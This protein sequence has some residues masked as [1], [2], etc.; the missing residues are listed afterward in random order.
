M[1]KKEQDFGVNDFAKKNIKIYDDA[2]IIG[3]ENIDF[4]HDI[5]IDDFVF[6]VA[7]KTIRIGNYVH[8]GAFS[9]IL[10]GEEL[11]MG[12]F[13][14]I[15]QGARIYTATEDFINGGF[16]NPT[17]DSKYRNAKRAPVKIGKFCVIGANSVILPGVE[18]GEGSVVGANS[19]VTKN[20]EP[21]GVYINNHRHKERNK[22]ELMER[23]KKFI[24]EEKLG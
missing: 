7:R 1:K 19:V 14:G 18:I 16:G 8:L 24:S 12:D 10:G 6:I 11:E 22:K 9:S 5:I 23:Y 4:G 2:K 17:M 15:S 13:S 3:I 21:W 20:L